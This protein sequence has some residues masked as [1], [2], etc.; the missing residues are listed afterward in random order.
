MFC[1]VFF[2]EG[3]GLNNNNNNEMDEYVHIYLNGYFFFPVG[4][5]RKKRKK[6]RSEFL[7]LQRIKVAVNERVDRMDEGINK[8]QND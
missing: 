8:V 3:K 7:F 6:L 1:F 2:L 4:N 5:K